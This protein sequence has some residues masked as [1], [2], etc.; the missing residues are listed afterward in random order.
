MIILLIFMAFF[1]FL[2]DSGHIIVTVERSEKGNLDSYPVFHYYSENRHR[3][4][5]E[6]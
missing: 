1:L 5:S 4:G 6:E 2:K 3:K